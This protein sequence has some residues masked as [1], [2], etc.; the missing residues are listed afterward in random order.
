[1]NKTATL[2]FLTIS[3]AAVFRCSAPERPSASR[4]SSADKI[5]SSAEAMLPTSPDAAVALL[6]D[7]QKQCT[8]STVRRYLESAMAKC[9]F[10]AYKDDSCLFYTAQ[11]EE[12]CTRQD[13]DKKD[14]DDILYLR[15]LNCNVRGICMQYSNERDSA[16][17]CFETAY[18]CFRKSSRKDRIADICINISDIHLQKG[19][20]AEAAIW[21]G[22]AEQAADSLG[23]D[24][25]KHAIATSRA[26]I[27]SRM[28]NFKEAEKYFN[29]AL[30][31]YPPTTVYEKYYIYNCLGN[32]YYFQKAYDK[33][34]DA[35]RIS[36]S[37]IKKL[38]QRPSEAISE[39][40]LGEI[41]I[42]LE[43]LDSAGFY[44]DR[45]GKW[46]DTPGADDGIRFY[47]NGLYAALYLEKGDL[48]SA[49]KYLSKPYDESR[50]GAAYLYE[51]HKRL[52]E[53]YSRSGDYR[54]ALEYS[55][56]ER[57]YDDSL[58]NVRYLNNVTEINARYAAD[59]TLLRKDVEIS[60]HVKTIAVQRQWIIIIVAILVLSGLGMY[61]WI[62]INRKKRMEERRKELRMI[63]D[64]RLKAARKMLSPHFIFNVLNTILPAMEQDGK[65]RESVGHLIN[66][67]RESLE[68]TEKNTVKISEEISLVREYVAL[69]M[70][71]SPVTPNILWNIS[72]NITGD[73]EIPNLAI[74]T[75]VENAI[76]YSGADIIAINIR[77][78]EGL[79]HIEISD[80]GI[81]LANS[82]RDQSEGTGNGI[83]IMSRTIAALNEGRKCKISY[84]IESTEGS[85]GTTVI[86]TI[87]EK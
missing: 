67:I 47:I 46:Y 40:N 3:T 15:G 72:E 85:K 83:L 33:A 49:G 45:A 52:A 41:F 79:L 80:D 8:D 10:Y 32:F 11:V 73:E 81:G 39:A 19:D 82:H 7:S 75:H 28:Y 36:Y 59:T 69:R 51:Y 66:L 78:G 12:Y 84:S 31:K 13:A 22:K 24:S 35:F 58:R 29:T 4:F 43:N 21:S 74:Q 42:H 76:K 44:L 38:N 61:A 64:L 9:Y 6:R 26:E 55:R 37:E 1:M 17:L 30:Y 53:Y 5:I 16:R 20:F 68:S 34:L 86:I 54:K 25:L 87:P 48:I 63:S 65:G 56:L 71:V 14:A 70:I 27:Y 62:S 60:T 50:I 57:A 23:Q 2:I 18:N 77:H